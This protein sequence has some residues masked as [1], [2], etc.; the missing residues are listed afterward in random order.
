[1]ACVRTYITSEGVTVRIM[2]DCYANCTPEELDARRREVRRVLD[3]IALNK[4]RRDAERAEA[5]EAGIDRT[6]EY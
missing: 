1:M 2:D 5:A 4:A 6:K 3:W